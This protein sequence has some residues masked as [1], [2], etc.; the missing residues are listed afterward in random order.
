MN[1]HHLALAVLAALALP[2]GSRA[3]EVIDAPGAVLRGLDKMSS[4]TT[5]LT[6]RDGETVPYGSLLITV[7]DCRSPQN[8]PASNAYA[9]VAVKDGAGASLFDGW[10]IASSP[11][12]SALDHPRYD[13]WVLRCMSN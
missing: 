5:D 10:M 11:A 4:Q 12:L 2:C 6:V 8:D 3:G 9:H 7:S 13:V 1:G